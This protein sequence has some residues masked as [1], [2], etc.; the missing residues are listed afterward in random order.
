MFTIK[1]KCSKGTFIRALAGDIGKKLKSGATVIR[2]V[3]TRNG[4][5]TADDA[6]KKEEINKIQNL[7]DLK[8][9]SIDEVMQYYPRLI[10]KSKYRDFILNGKEI[11][12]FYFLDFGDTLAEGIYKIQDTSERLL[13]II[14]YKKENF[15]YLKV[16]SH[17]N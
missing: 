9:Y 6:V 14:E 5:F 4:L 12:R 13:A 17:D 8:I 1:V 11:N 15:Y 2:L 7:S 16:F 3:R 10:V